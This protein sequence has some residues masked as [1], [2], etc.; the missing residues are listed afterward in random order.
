MDVKCPGYTSYPL[1]LE[2]KKKKIGSLHQA[3]FDITSILSSERERER[4]RERFIIYVI[5]LDNCEHTGQLKVTIQL[6]FRG[7]H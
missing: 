1:N 4:E 6:E 2:K 3:S 7:F 5:E